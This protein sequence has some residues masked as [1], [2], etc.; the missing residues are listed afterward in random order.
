MGGEFYNLRLNEEIE[1]NIG[2][3][4]G[5]FNWNDPEE[6]VDIQIE[7]GRKV[8]SL[9]KVRGKVI[10]LKGKQQKKNQ[11]WKYEQDIEKLEKENNKLVNQL[12]DFTE[13]MDSRWEIFREHQDRNR[14]GTQED[15]IIPPQNI[16]P[17]EN[18]N[19]LTPSKFISILIVNS[20][21]FNSETQG[22]NEETE[23]EDKNPFNQTCHQWNV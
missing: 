19:P 14:H 1:T 20:Q 23:K 6:N 9:R 11:E 17:T 3:K 22:H 18:D 8:A 5:D 4:G 16:N 7:S 12:L 13:Q 2:E 21:G 15:G 10:K